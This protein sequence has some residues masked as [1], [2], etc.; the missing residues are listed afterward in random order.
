VRIRGELAVLVAGQA[1]LGAAAAAM[2]R[3]LAELTDL[4]DTVE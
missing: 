1:M 3:T 2:G 4:D